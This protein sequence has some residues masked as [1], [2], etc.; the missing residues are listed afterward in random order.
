MKYIAN[1]IIVDAFVI[2]ETSDRED[3]NGV[4]VTLDNGEIK[5][6]D[7]SMTAR[8]SPVA[9]DYWVIQEDGYAYLNPKGVFEK[10][11]SLVVNSPGPLE[12]FQPMN[13]ADGNA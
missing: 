1:P 12:G 8:M 7:S 11:Y 2:S 13:P 9:G 4:D 3:D 5:H 6:A 10:K